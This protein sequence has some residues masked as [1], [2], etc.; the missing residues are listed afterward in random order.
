MSIDSEQQVRLLNE[1]LIELRKLTA[2][3]EQIVADYNLTNEI[4]KLTKIVERAFG[5]SVPG[6]TGTLYNEQ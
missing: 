6:Y 2:E 5:G 1:I 4:P 3:P